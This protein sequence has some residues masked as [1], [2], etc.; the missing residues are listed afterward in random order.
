MSILQRIKD[1]LQHRNVWWHFV[2]D[3]DKPGGTTGHIAREGRFYLHIGGRQELHWSWNHW[4]S[5]AHAY[6]ELG[7][8]DDLTIGIAAPPVAYWFS[9]GRLPRALMDALP[10]A[11]RREGRGYHNP[12]RIGIGLH[13]AA[14]WW[15]IW[16]DGHEWRA[17]D[18]KWMHGSWHP[19]DTFFGRHEHKERTIEEREVSIPMPERGY[20]AKVRM[21]VETWERPRWPFWPMRTEI[22]RAHIDV[23][24]GIGMPG[25]GEND[26]D[27]GDDATY[28]L[29]CEART[30][31]DGVGKL[32]ASVLRDRQRR[33]GSHTFTPS[34]APG[35]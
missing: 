5:F 27:I 31:E 25:K 11:W 29:T 23:P 21:A 14:I 20:P 10:W 2:N 33:G 3:N 8:E 35:A 12:R 16:A 32:V 17:S 13:D 22:V 6:V 34:S 4:A 9:V 1:R 19:L 18:P 24:E 7:G 26:Y 15:D 28:G 30:V